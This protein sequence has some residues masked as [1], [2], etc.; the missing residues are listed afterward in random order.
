LR[1]LPQQIDFDRLLQG[2]FRSRRLVECPG[3]VLE[4][5]LKGEGA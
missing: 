1:H 2:R 3:H 4:E 5:Y